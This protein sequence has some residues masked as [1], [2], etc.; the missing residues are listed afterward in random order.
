MR[1]QIVRSLQYLYF[2][3]FSLFLW[4]FPL[5][6]ALLDSGPTRTLTRG[7]FV[8]EYT[9][10]YLCVA[11]Y[12]I[13]KAFVALVTARA[14][15]INGGDRFA[16][17]CPDWLCNL[18][19]EQNTGNE[20]K[21][22]TVAILPALAVFVYLALV[23]IAEDIPWHKI[24]WGVAVG[25]FLA[26]LFWYVVNAWYY[27]AYEIP[28]GLE[29][30][31]T[32]TLG[33]NAARTIL[34]PRQWF[35]LNPP[36]TTMATRRLTLEDMKSPL[37]DSG[38]AKWSH[39][40]AGEL[41]Q[42][43]GLPG[44]IYADNYIYEAHIFAFIAAV[45]FFVLFSILYPL[46]AP[47]PTRWAVLSFAILFGGLI[48]VLWI[49]LGST[50]VNGTMRRWRLLLSSAAVLFCGAIFYAWYHSSPDRFPT[51]ASVLLIVVLLGWGLCAAS[52]FLDRYRIPVLTL[53]ILAAV[54]PRAVCP[55]LFY[56]NQEDHY[57]STAPLSGD[58]GVPTPGQ[59]LLDR[60]NLAEDDGRPLIVVTSTGGGLHAS[61]WTARILET[62]TEQLPAADQESFRRHVLLM[63]TVSGSS[64][65]EA[66]Y[67]E[68]LQ[69]A[70]NE[71]RSPN[72]HKVVIASQ[73]SSLEAVG[74]GL[75]YYDLTKAM[76]P[77]LGWVNPSSGNGDLSHSPLGKDRTWALR[78]GMQR[79]VNSG[80]CYDSAYDNATD[81]R[82]PD[83]PA[84]LSLLE[85]LWPQQTG[86]SRAPTLANMRASEAIPAF[87]MNTTTVEGGDRF[88][89]ANYRL[90]SYRIGPLEGPP[91]ESFLDLK[92]HDGQFAD[93]PLATAAQL[94]ATFPYVSS[95]ARIPRTY[96]I[97]SAHFVDGGYYDNDG[98]SSMIEFLRYALDPPLQA[99]ATSQQKQDASIQQAVADKLRAKPSRPQATKP[100]KILLVEI[101]NSQ[102]SDRSSTRSRALN[103]DGSG[104]AGLLEHLAMP[105]KGFWSAGH[106]SVTGRDRNGLDLLIASHRENL[107]LHQIVF[108]DVTEDTDR[109]WI[110][111]A[112]DPLSWSLTPAERGEVAN[113]ALKQCTIGARY[114]AAMDWFLGFDKEWSK[115]P[116]GDASNPC[117]EEK[118]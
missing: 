26:F 38:F 16:A 59:M 47:V 45:G 12:L 41:N 50:A 20:R 108:D 21:A 35:F 103:P 51:L 76:V 13:S 9:F 53:L 111:N 34:F 85:R 114:Q 73:C 84:K 95:A 115:S 101:R 78:R 64:F 113:H 27:L 72:L 60:L 17:P 61:A 63:S 89:L 30:T 49:F 46:T 29:D 52:F 14:I 18:L 96:S 79:N 71:H 42:L 15:I 110:K 19:A 6:F 88:L 33:K 109:F 39:R 69:Q 62:L 117:P 58:P 77:F 3:R 102:D 83:V 24:A 107:Q 70:E 87:T 48:S 31:P 75:L 90:P 68:E 5:A 106:D 36:E 100:V 43:I 74:W 82:L 118:R 28:P 4:L 1:A 67:L 54:L 44:Y 55:S 8:P 11:F 56:G 7:I 32:L 116:Q 25:T 93:L 97:K 99:T 2:L 98:T 81:K 66:Y 40:L 65:A 22:V 105:L 23:G 80:Y 86:E 10:G 94:S 91:A 92:L 57:L 104:H 37:R 112:K